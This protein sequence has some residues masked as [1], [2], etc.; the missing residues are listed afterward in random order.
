LTHEPIPFF[1][2]E[3]GPAEIDE[4]VAAMQ[5]G[6]LTSGPRVRKFEEEFA[7]FVGAK[8]AVALN[9]ATAALHLAL[10]A[11][12]IGPGDE[13][14]LPTM[15]FVATAEVV[16][17]L[18]ARP[19]LVDCLPG[20]LLVDP[21]AVERAIS[22]RTKAVMPV[23]YGGAACDMD[24]LCSLAEQHKLHLVEDAAHALPTRYRGRTIGSIGDLTAFSFYANKTITTGEGGMLTTD[25]AEYA[26]RART[27][28][29]HGL[30]RDAWKRFAAGGSWQ[31]TI[32]RPGY[33]YNMTD[34][35]AAMGIHQL[36]RAEAFRTE[37]ERCAQRYHELLADVAELQLPEIPSPDD[38][39]RSA[40]HLYVVQIRPERLRIDRNQ[41]IAALAA[42][43]ISTS[44]HWLP[45]HM[46]PYYR[47]TFGYGEQDFPVAHTAF[48]RI[49]SLPIFP[50]MSEEQL[51]RVAAMLREIVGKALN[52]NDE[53]GNPK[54]E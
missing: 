16:L 30:S 50:S 41:V 2:P 52:P 4:V 43:G 21:A 27:M 47:E 14:I 48:E 51:D 20:T 22:P 11:I 6:W 1:R 38:A 18:G 40:W 5:S 25:N 9:S 13:V 15:T 10:D 3:I 19:V 29:L 7:S 17:H 28:S 39:T 42:A 37:R 24:A 26:D 34:I 49:V 32:E 54:H 44:V 36:R 33:K 8:H 45:L 31:Y 35:A 12:G 53:R 23:H 46:H